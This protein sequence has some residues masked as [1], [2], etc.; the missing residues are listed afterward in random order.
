MTFPLGSLREGGGSSLVSSAAGLKR[1]GSRRAAVPHDPAGWR[2]QLG[3]LIGA[4]L[5]LLAVLA[6]AT[7][8]PADPA[9]STSGTAAVT[10]NKAGALGAW[11]SDL[12][13]FLFGYS[14]WWAVAVA[15]RAWLGALARVLRTDRATRSA[16]EVW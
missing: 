11:F 14:I 6:L 3:L 10:L 7:H 9:F 8:N 16:T 2:A 12:A 4:V 15:L 1:D 13:Y 5:W